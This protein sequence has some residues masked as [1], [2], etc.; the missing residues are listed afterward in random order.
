MPKTPIRSERARQGAG[1]PHTTDVIIRGGDQKPPPQTAAPLLSPPL[2]RDAAAFGAPDP[3]LGQRVAAA[4]QLEDDSDEAAIDHIL[5]FI[6]ERLADGKVP[7]LLV[8]VDAVPR[9]ARGEIDREAVA[10]AILGRPAHR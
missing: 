4:V 3:E 6:A 2:V 7:E 5:G 9:N 8:A 1:E 10:E